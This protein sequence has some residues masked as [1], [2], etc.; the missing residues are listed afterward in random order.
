MKKIIVS[1]NQVKSI[2]DNLLFEQYHDR[3]MVKSIQCFLNMIL[4][5]NLTIDG[6]SGP[7]SLTEKTLKE[8]QLKKKQSGFNIDIDGVWGYR[9]QS[10][11]TPEE[12]KVWKQCVRK[13]NL[14]E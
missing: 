9:T 8:F 10:T 1:E 5:S 11:L 2:I 3:T 12:Q 4:G 6:L 14:S 7:N 13:Y